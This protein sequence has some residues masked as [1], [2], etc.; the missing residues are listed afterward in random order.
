MT[1]S[2]PDTV[3]DGD[4]AS[5]DNDSG[6]VSSPTWQDWTRLLEEIQAMQ[7]KTLVDEHAGI[8]T[9]NTYPGIVG[10][11]TGNAALRK[12]TFVLTDVEMIITDAGAAG[13]HGTI[14]LYTFTDGHTDIYTGAIEGDLSAGTGGI[15]NNAVLDIA[16]GSTTVSVA[17]ETLAL[18]EQ[19]ISTKDDVTLTGGSKAFSA[20][21][22]SQVDMDG[23]L[24][25]YLNVAIENASCNADDILTITGRCVIIWNNHH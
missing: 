12:T 9:I 18:T 8:G 20:T 4:S 1:A 2:F 6:A 23:E 5:R 7:S 3:W 17:D 11:E 25:L 15:A 24:A 14:K 10:S 13:A 19:N 21:N 22:L 16:M